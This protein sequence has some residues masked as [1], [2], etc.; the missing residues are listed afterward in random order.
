MPESTVTLIFS[1]AVCLALVIGVGWLVSAQ[2]KAGRAASGPEGT[3]GERDDER[4]GMQP[5]DWLNA[6]VNV[7]VG[8][9]LGIAIDG[10]VRLLTT[11]FWPVAVVIPALFVG[12]FLL[13]ESFS[14]LI[15]RMFPGGVR[16]ALKTRARRRRPRP[17]RLSLPVGLLL[18]VALA[19]LGLGDGLLRLMA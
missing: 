13:N 6:S 8:L 12:V 9:F 5:G 4:R 7:V 17:R 15:D 19:R 14:R 2:L 10:I 18:G 3:A 16:P 1:V 11:A